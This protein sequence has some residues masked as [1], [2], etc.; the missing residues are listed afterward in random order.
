LSLTSSKIAWFAG[1][2]PIEQVARCARGHTAN[3][4]AS[5]SLPPLVAVADTRRAA[6]VLHTQTDTRTLPPG[7]ADDWCR[8]ICAKTQSAA[9]GGVWLWLGLGVG[10]GLVSDG[11]GLE[12]ELE[13]LGL[14]L[15]LE[16]ELD[17]LGLGL[18]LDG[19]ALVGLVLDG[20]ALVGLVLDGL[21]PE[22]EGLGLRE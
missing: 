18:V 10:D 15:G 6:T 8:M 7:A 4:G 14:G 21:A 13:G 22:L 16:L 1:S 17:G 12:L 20:L 19:L 3:V 11:L 5:M 9:G 2:E